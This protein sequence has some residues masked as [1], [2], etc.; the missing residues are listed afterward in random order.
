MSD[1]RILRALALLALGRLA[2]SR[3]AGRTEL[4][5]GVLA[6]QLEGVELEALELL[7]L[8][9]LQLHLLQH[10]AV[11]EIGEELRDDLRVEAAALHLEVTLLGAELREPHALG[12]L[13]RHG[14]HQAHRTGT[15][16]LDLVDHRELGL[17]VGLLRLELLDLLL[18][19]LEA[20]ELLFLG[21]QL[22]AVRA[23]LRGHPDLEHQAET[24]AETRGAGEIDALPQLARLTA[25]LAD[26]QEVDSDHDWSSRRMA[27][28][29]ATH[30]AG[31]SSR[32]RSSSPA[33]EPISMRRNGSTTSTLIPR[34]SSNRRSSPGAEAA[35][36]HSSSRSTRE[37]DVV[38]R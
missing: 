26:G 3:R 21:R 7:E 29:S 25:R 22:R 33:P 17:D 2:G 6:L 27:R 31:P 23:D 28:P 5:E 24:H 13:G 16:P 32:I 10:L 9:L 4:R 14:V 12:D 11:L 18:R 15:R 35:P 19:L 36:P 1:P 38:A 37:L 34:R 8:R 20:F 30:S